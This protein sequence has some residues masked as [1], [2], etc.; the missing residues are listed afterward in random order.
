MWINPVEKTKF[1]SQI[2]IAIA[3][4]SNLGKFE[5]TYCSDKQQRK[6]RNLRFIQKFQICYSY[7]HPHANSLKITIEKRDFNQAL[8]DSLARNMQDQALLEALAQETSKSRHFEPECDFE[9]LF[10]TPNV[11]K[12]LNPLENFSALV[13]LYSNLS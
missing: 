12:F 10:H 7:S 9:I 1:R 4:F 3:I 13:Y 6:F 11:T 8:L 5:T 2:C